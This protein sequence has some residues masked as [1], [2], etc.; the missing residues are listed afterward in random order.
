[1]QA[2]ALVQICVDWPTAMR[3]RVAPPPDVLGCSGAKRAASRAAGAAGE[4]V[5]RPT[6]WHSTAQ[7]PVTRPADTCSP[8]STQNLQ[9]RPWR[10]APLAH[11][12]RRDPQAQPGPPRRARPTLPSAARRAEACGA[13]RAEVSGTLALHQEEMSSAPGRHTL[14]RSVVRR[15][16]VPYVRR[17]RRRPASRAPPRSTARR[18]RRRRRCRSGRGRRVVGG[19][20][21][22][23]RSARWRA[24]CGETSRRRPTRCARMSAHPGGIARAPARAR[25]AGEAQARYAEERESLLRQAMVGAAQ[26]LVEYVEAAARGGGGADA[27]AARR[28]GLSPAAARARSR[29]PRRSAALLALGAICVTAGIASAA[30][31]TAAVG[32]A[33]DAAVGV[34]PHGRERGVGADE[35]G[36]GGVLGGAGGGGSARRPSSRTLARR[37]AAPP[38]PRRLWRRRSGG[39]VPGLLHPLERPFALPFYL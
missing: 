11:Q 8:R 14:R 35:A 10:L 1:M 24:S 6:S 3:L 17:R 29:R 31:S 7:F 9:R 19:G 39:R 13:A 16:R 20:E 27:D 12:P 26:R 32:R 36:A 33:V 28:I 15:R 22:R 34:A 5:G 4:E 37:R 25:R 30:L 23:R 21:E 38:P 2:A 18:S